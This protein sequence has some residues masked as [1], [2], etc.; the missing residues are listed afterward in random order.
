MSDFQKELEKSMNLIVK[1]N[2]KFAEKLL[3]CRPWNKVVDS[4]I[5]DRN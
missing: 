2:K 1:E 5:K 3:S 4:A